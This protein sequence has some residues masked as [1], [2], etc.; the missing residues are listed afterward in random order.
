MLTRVMLPTPPLRAYVHH[1]W[2]MKTERISAEMNIV[3]TGSMKWMFHRRTPLVV[4]GMV[5]NSNVAS[6]CGQYMRSINVQTAQSTHLLFVFFRPY[7]LKMIM[8]M[9]SDSFVED[10]VSMDLLGMPGFHDLKCRVLDSPTDDEAIAIIEAFIMRRLYN[11]GDSVYLKP[12]IA[13]CSAIDSDPTVSIE[14]LS[15]IACLSERQFRR[16][17]TEHVGMT[18]KQMIRTKRFFYATKMMQTL[19]ESVFTTIVDDLGFTDHSHF[20]KE[21]RHFSGM[22]P[23]EYLAHLCEIKRTDFIRGYRAYHE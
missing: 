17:F 23:T 14:R 5:D 8:G 16:I 12:L 4:N 9:P 10:N 13:A 21:F 6:V 22:S 1:Y 19:D 7:A 20:N 11:N 3:P 18:P 15:D 2:V